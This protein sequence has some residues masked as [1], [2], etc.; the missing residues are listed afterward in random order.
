M[1]YT[2]LN[3]IRIRAN[4]IGGMLNEITDYGR[5][6]LPDDFADFDR[7]W[8]ELAKIIQH[9]TKHPE[10]FR[11]GIEVAEAKRP[12]GGGKLFEN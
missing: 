8:R 3:D 5:R 4:K 1:I 11:G 10:L 7:E 12:P 2:C 9:P 6:P